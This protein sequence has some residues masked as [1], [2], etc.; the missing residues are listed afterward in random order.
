MDDTKRMILI[1]PRAYNY[2]KTSAITNIEDAI[3]ELM[4]NSDDAYHKGNYEIR[5]YDIEINYNK[6]ENSSGNLIV[7]DHAIGLNG[8]LMEKCFLQVGQ[9]TSDNTSRGF[10]S[11]GAKDISSLGDVTFESIKDN[12]YTKVILDVDSYGSI[13]YK[14]IDVTKEIREKLKL[15]ENGLV[16]TINL[17]DKVTLPSPE[18]IKITLPK[19]VSLR[20]IFNDSKNIIMLKTI[21]NDN[22]NEERLTY[23]FP[24]GQ[25]IMEVDYI[26]PGYEGAEA[27]FKVLKSTLQFSRPSIRKLQEFGFIIK[28]ERVLHDI[29]SFDHDLLFDPDAQYFW[30][31]ID[32]PHINK[33]MRDFDFNN[34]TRSNPFPIIDPN[35]I[36]GINKTHPFY[37]ALVQLPIKRMKLILEEMDNDDTSG[38]QNF[39]MS[40]IN[41]IVKELDLIEPDLFKNPDNKL[42]L[43]DDNKSKL[44]RAIEKEREQIVKIEKNFLLE[45][46]D[47]IGDPKDNSQNKN[48]EDEKEN[49]KLDDPYERELRIQL[50]NNLTKNNPS[51]NGLLMKEKTLEE[52]GDMKRVFV[53]EKNSIRYNE[54]FNESERFTEAK[55]D[56]KFKILFKRD[57][58]KD[59]KFEIKRTTTSITIKVNICHHLIKDYFT[60]EKMEIKELSGKGLMVLENIL[61][62]SFTRLIMQNEALTGKNRVEGSN[63]AELL[64]EIM[65][66]KDNKEKGIE[67][68]VYAIIKKMINE[69]TKYM[70]Q[71]YQN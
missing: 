48:L 66:W 5:K 71:L 20:G 12:K 40:E 32:C 54:P 42:N 69:R 10:F 1:D 35:R 36:Q 17:L 56:I 11:R 44:I 55:E 13:P 15:P 67:R 26:V 57:P 43:V 51:L 53:Y 41:K 30:G 59:Y 45:A 50:K 68:L 46:F 19:I 4:T 27:T 64:E 39:D 7:R 58:R 6:T 61:T 63:T 70:E 60:T 9:F 47:Y 49:D 33:L 3:V 8:D 24:S 2:M 28:S 31:F 52:V 21:K 62:E 23:D 65:S 16:A 29:D 37:K 18:A 25:V 38:M 34:K 14:D 22:I